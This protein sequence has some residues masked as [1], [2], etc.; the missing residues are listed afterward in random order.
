L[1]P[2]P[3]PSCGFPVA[4]HGFGLCT[5]G[6]C[7]AAHN[8]GCPLQHIIRCRCNSHHLSHYS[9]LLTSGQTQRTAMDQLPS[10][11]AAQLQVPR[12]TRKRVILSCRPCRTSKLKCDRKAPC[13]QCQRRGHTANE[14]V[15][16]PKPPTTRK[17]R[18]MAARLQE[19]QGTIRQFIH[20]SPGSSRA[21]TSSTADTNDKTGAR[22]VTDQR[23]K[24]TYVGA[25]HFMTVLDD[26]GSLVCCEVCPLTCLPAGRSQA[27]L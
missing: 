15:Y 19:I 26:V 2:S 4:C 18:S 23:G 9:N 11:L 17:S 5:F 22:V 12:R 25:T 8:E 21:S 24:S 10:D 16:E 6:L 14:C 3:N 20:E 13:T 7:R 1:L 27:V